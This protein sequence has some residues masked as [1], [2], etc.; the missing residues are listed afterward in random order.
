MKLAVEL[1]V[2]AV[3]V[4]F[5]FLCMNKRKWT[6]REITVT[7]NFN[8]H[9]CRS[10]DLVLY[11][12]EGPQCPYPGHLAVVVTLPRYKQ[13][14][15]WEMPN[16][17]FH[18]PDLLKPISS[19]FANGKR[20]HSRAQMYVQSLQGP[21]VNLLPFVKHMSANAVFDFQSAVTCA[22]NF[23]KSVFLMPPFPQIHASQ[24]HH[25]Y[26]S[27][28]I[29]SVLQRACVLSKQVMW[30]NDMVLY[31]MSLLHPDF[32]INAFTEPGFRY[33]SPVRIF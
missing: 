5:C 3:F 7:D 21:E 25:Y 26:C 17:L 14:F 31:P 2:C 1:F 12:K 20:N 24:R 9:S 8:L 15:V 10:G 11:L 27:N 19:Y 28:A 33:A 30:N 4:F 22:N 32:D 13:V 18:G 16:G 29:F 6:V 23:L